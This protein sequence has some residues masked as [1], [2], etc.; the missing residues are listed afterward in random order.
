MGP[1]GE[2]FHSSA[3][4]PRTSRQYL[5][6]TI[7]N[8]P[9]KLRESGLDEFVIPTTQEAEIG[10]I[11]VQGQFSQKVNPITTNACD[12]SY[13]GSINRKNLVHAYPGRKARPHLK[14]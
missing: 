10:Q 9:K 1:D 5:K 14:K 11:M 8:L 2:N 4:L 7:I 13:A 12:L 6:T 3:I